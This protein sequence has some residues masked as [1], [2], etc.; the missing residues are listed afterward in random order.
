MKKTGTTTSLMT[1]MKKTEQ[2]HHRWHICNLTLQESNIVAFML[3]RSI[4]AINST[5]IRYQQ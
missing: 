1:Q 2:L 3:K 4:A 5:R